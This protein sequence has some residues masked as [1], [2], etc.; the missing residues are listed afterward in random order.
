MREEKERQ[1]RGWKT[2]EFPKENPKY[3]VIA[4]SRLPS[5][6][7]WK[8]T[9]RII[10]RALFK[11]IELDCPMVRKRTCTMKLQ[12]DYNVVSEE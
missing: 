2:K 11:Y 6:T 4:A 8:I 9:G 12:M 1:K 7:C 5:H 10:V 3:V